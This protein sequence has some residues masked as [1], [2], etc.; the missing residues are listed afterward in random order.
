[1]E[2]SQYSVEHNINHLETKCQGVGW[3]ICL[4]SV[5]TVSSAGK[6]DMC[7]PVCAAL[8]R[9]AHYWLHPTHG[10]EFVLESLG[11][12]PAPS[13][14]WGNKFYQ[15]SVSN[16]LEPIIT[17]FNKVFNCSSY[18]QSYYVSKV[19]ISLW[20]HLCLFGNLQNILRKL[21]AFTLN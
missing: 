9:W 12:P 1:M 20:N 19:L 15:C 13:L 21:I 16:S 7:T 11:N 17:G 8:Q 6:E 2:K 5:L 4:C 14:Q 18:L 3:F 10:A